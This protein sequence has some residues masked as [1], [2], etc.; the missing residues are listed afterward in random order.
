MP[1][2]STANRP[3]RSALAAFLR[4]PFPRGWLRPNPADGGGDPLE[5]LRAAWAAGASVP[6]VVRAIAEVVDDTF[7]WLTRVGIVVDPHLRAPLRVATRWAD[8]RASWAELEVAYADAYRAHMGAIAV[9]QGPR[10]D[11]DVALTVA[12]HVAAAVFAVLA[13]AYDPQALVSL[14]A[15]RDEVSPLLTRRVSR[16]LV[17]GHHA[18]AYEAEEVAVAVAAASAVLNARDI[19][20]VL[21]VDEAV[22]AGK[23]AAA[24]RRAFGAT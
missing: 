17:S 23:V 20:V 11:G 6:A 12:S 15:L 5:V 19:R 24:L 1:T 18:E 4:S 8:G 9:T 13:A 7:P 22:A 2:P 16:L 21:D 10:A 3:A 14:A